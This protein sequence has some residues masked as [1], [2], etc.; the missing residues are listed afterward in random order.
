MSDTEGI[1]LPCDGFEV[2]LSRA[3]SGSRTD[4]TTERNHMTRR[5]FSAISRALRVDELTPDNVHFH[6][7]S[8][9]RAYPC[10]NARC[11]SPGLDVDSG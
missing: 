8:A 4:T 2:P 11:V 6:A 1:I 7:D 10:E 3:S 5:L 9:G